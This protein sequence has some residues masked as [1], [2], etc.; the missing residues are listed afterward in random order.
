MS[1]M[2]AY[3]FASTQQ[4]LFVTGRKTHASSFLQAVMPDDPASSSPHYLRR[5]L[6]KLNLDASG[7]VLRY[8]C[9]G[10]NR[11]MP[12]SDDPTY[13][14]APTPVVSEGNSLPFE[15]GVGMRVDVQ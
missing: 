2:K 8:A 4:R 14:P 12:I 10:S 6:R 11:H 13:R 9:R 15:I 5:F 3:P 1:H 7:D